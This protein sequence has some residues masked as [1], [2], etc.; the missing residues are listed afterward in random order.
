VASEL[1]VAVTSAAE[2]A[3][4][5]LARALQRRRDRKRRPG[6]S[7]GGEPDLGLEGPPAGSP[8]SE[9]ADR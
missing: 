1:E 6:V 2:G 5:S 8:A 3:A 4:R 7:M 9:A